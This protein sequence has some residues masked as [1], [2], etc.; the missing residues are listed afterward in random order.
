MSLEH[1]MEVR[2]NPRRRSLVHHLEFVEGAGYSNLKRGHLPLCSLCVAI[3]FVILLGC[4]IF[5]TT[6]MATL[7]HA[8]S[9]NS[10]L[11]ST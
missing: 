2:H 3:P 5:L 1:C 7:L 11:K 10:R 8:L 6:T 9:I 4:K